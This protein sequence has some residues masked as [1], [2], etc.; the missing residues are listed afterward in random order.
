[1]NPILENKEVL[2]LIEERRK[3]QPFLLPYHFNIGKAD[4]CKGILKDSATPDEVL[5]WLIDYG[6]NEDKCRVASLP[7][8]NREMRD[9]LFRIE[10]DN[11]LAA[12]AKNPTLDQDEYE[13]LLTGSDAIKLSLAQNEK[14]PTEILKVLSTNL[15]DQ[16]IIN[17]TLS[18]PNVPV[19]IIEHLLHL[20]VFF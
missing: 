14:T 19:E 5:W 18:N 4:Y 16:T 8:C 10:N 3:L 12:M 15:Q 1:M 9:K 6:D 17:A 2:E 13:I 11:V 20:F 7:R